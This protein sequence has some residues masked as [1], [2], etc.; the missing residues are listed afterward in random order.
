[1][2]LTKKFHL[3]VNFKNDLNANQRVLMNVNVYKYQGYDAYFAVF[4][5]R[6]I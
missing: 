4:V 3:T 1:M 5:T 2:I 6:E